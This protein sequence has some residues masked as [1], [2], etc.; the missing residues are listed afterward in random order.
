MS[1]REGRESEGEKREEM[2]RESGE[3]GRERW[4]ERG[5]RERERERNKILLKKSRSSF[6]SP[7][8]LHRTSLNNDC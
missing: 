3:R 4:R 6:V 7:Y 8:W 2:E 1:E 5:E